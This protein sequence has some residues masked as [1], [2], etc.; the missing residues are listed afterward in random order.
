MKIF[1]RINRNSK[2]KVVENSLLHHNENIIFHGKNSEKFFSE[3]KNYMKSPTDRDLDFFFSCYIFKSD[4]KTQQSI[5][6]V[7][8]IKDCDYTNKKNK[9][10]SFRYF[11]IIKIKK[12]A[13]NYFQL[14]TDL[15]NLVV[16]TN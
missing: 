9:K 7:K 8:I 1:N 5:N 12:I 15:E 4:F 14:L 6:N 2:D 3:K 16:F 11:L 13:D 10:F